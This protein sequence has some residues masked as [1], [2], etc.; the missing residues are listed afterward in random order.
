M[1]ISNLPLPAVEPSTPVPPCAGETVVSEERTPPVVVTIPLVDRPE[2][3]I[4]PE[5]VM[6]PILDKFPTVVP[7]ET[8]KIVFVPLLILNVP[9]DPWV[10]V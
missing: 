10:K 2:K 7:S 9:P 6:P 5:A 3:V 1:P 4:V 8:E